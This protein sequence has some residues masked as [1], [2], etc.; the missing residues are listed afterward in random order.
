MGLGILASRA[1]ALDELSTTAYRACA[2]LAFLGGVVIVAALS[3]KEKVGG[4]FVG[5]ALLAG[6]LIGAFTERAIYVDRPDAVVS[7]CGLEVTAI[8]AATL[9][10]FIGAGIGGFLLAFAF[11][12]RR[13]SK[14]APVVGCVLAW[15]VAAVLCA[16]AGS[17]PA[18]ALCAVGVVVQIAF[19]VTLKRASVVRLGPYR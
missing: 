11:A 19:A 18:V 17:V 1:L 3:R 8:E 2:T 13:A 7:F 16:L 12:A 5:M 10:A 6:A 14:R 4:A 15:V 9:G